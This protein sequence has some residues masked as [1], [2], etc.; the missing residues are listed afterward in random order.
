MKVKVGAEGVGRGMFIGLKVVKL[1][2][3]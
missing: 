3:I 1:L 2:T